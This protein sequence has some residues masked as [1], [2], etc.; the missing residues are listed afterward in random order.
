MIYRLSV[1]E[2]S[3]LIAA[4]VF[5]ARF[6]LPNAFALILVRLLGQQENAATWGFAQRALSNTHWPVMLRTDSMANRA[7]DTKIR[8]LNWLQIAFTVILAVAAVLTPA[9]LYDIISDGTTT[10]ETNFT[11]AQDQSVFGFSTQV[12]NEWPWRVCS[13]SYPLNDSILM[14]VNCPGSDQ[15]FTMTHNSSGYFQDW[16]GSGHLVSVNQ[17]RA[18]IFQSGLRDQQYTVSSFFDIKPRRIKRSVGDYTG[19]FNG[20]LPV[21]T[22]HF[23]QSVVDADRYQI[24]EGVIVDAKSGGVGLRNHTV[25]EHIPFGTSWTEDLLFLDLDVSC[26]DMNLSLTY[27]VIPV[28]GSNIAGSSIPYQLVDDGGFA[29]L[30][31]G[32]LPM[33]PPVTQQDLSLAERTAVTAYWTLYWTMNQPIM[34]LSTSGV[35]NPT[36]SRIGQTFMSED[37]YGAQVTQTDSIAVQPLRD[38]LVG[39]ILGYNSS[40]NAT[41]GMLNGVYNSTVACTGWAMD[42]FV[43]VSSIPI[44]CNLLIGAP[45]TVNGE[46]FDVAEEGMALK[47]KIYAFSAAIKATI[48]TV[49]FTYNGTGET[50]LEGLRVLDIQQ[51]NYSDENSMPLWAIETPPLFN[52]N[53]HPLWGLVSRDYE[54]VANISTFRSPQAY[55]VFW[56]AYEVLT[57]GTD[58]IGDNYLTGSSALSALLDYI[59]LIDFSTTSIGLDSRFVNGRNSALMLRRWQSLSKSA[60]SASTIIKLVF[61]N[62]AANYLQGG[63]GWLSEDVVPPPFRNLTGTRTS[64][65]VPTFNQERSVRFKWPYGIPAFLSLLLMMVLILVAIG[66]AATGSVHRVGR[67]LSLLSAGRLLTDLLP[68]GVNEANYQEDYKR[69]ARTT[70]KRPIQ[71]FAW[72]WKPMFPS[73]PWRMETMSSGRGDNKAV[74]TTT[75]SDIG[76]NTTGET[77]RDESRPFLDSSRG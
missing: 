77:M 35:P 62:L 69:W 16:D 13:D 53:M 54:N 61:T 76:S 43:N 36:K 31:P 17:S 26:V 38:F 60:E 19:N 28:N 39:G 34:N 48:K 50:P 55:P 22:Y 41:F 65:L 56:P 45:L 57:S 37:K 3:T 46:P 51:K 66:F 59:K 9:G 49:Q 8:T 74:L 23:I 67:Y 42:Y 32:L 30:D 15:S 27:D 72:G 21:D 5:I 4:V 33:Y 29:N 44:A 7:V 20:V 73:S 40:D 25:P 18:T 1:G 10:T 68:E 58:Y 64:A 70:G 2:I 12:Q 6:I 75:I 63:R 11:R 47:R 24:L 14:S 52:G 71:S